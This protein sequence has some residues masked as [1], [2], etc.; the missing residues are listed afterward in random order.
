MKTTLTAVVG[1]A[2]A[3]A[4]AAAPAS[5]ATRQPAKC[6]AHRSTTELATKD[7]RVYSLKNGRVYG[8]LLKKNKRVLL[9]TAGDCQGSPEPRAFR[10]AGRYVGFVSTACNLDTADETVIVADL[11]TGTAKLAA[12]AFAPPE[13]LPVHDREPNTGVV[14]FYMTDKGS[15]VWTGLFDAAGKRSLTGADDPDDLVQVRKAEPGSP[16]TGTTVDQD[17]DIAL[18]SLALDGDGF[19]YRKG[20]TPLFAPLG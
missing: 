3:I 10:L 14:G 19:Y 8:C 15:A 20:E 13:G 7:A 1:A 5:A 2:L 12:P 6:A 18:R 11:T 16:K 4:V 17:H 9:G